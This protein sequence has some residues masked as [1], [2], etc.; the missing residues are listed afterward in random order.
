MALYSNGRH[1]TT[2]APFRKRRSS[3]ALQER[4]RRPYAVESRTAT[5]LSALQWSK[6]LFLHAQIQTPELARESHE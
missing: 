3:A 2:F 1:A 6:S 4:K 5:S